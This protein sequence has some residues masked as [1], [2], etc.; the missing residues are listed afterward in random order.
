MTRA[1]V[2]RLESDCGML[3]DSYLHGSLNK[4][5]PPPGSCLNTWS[6]GGKV[7]EGLWKKCG[8]GGGL[9]SLPLLAMPLLCHFGL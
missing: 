5:A 8:I 4:N 1:H 7:W 6:P 9:P 3:W 2:E